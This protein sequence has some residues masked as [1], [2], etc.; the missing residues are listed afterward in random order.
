MQTNQV[1]LSYNYLV[2]NAIKL[3]FNSLLPTHYIL[4]DSFSILACAHD[5]RILHNQSYLP[6]SKL[7]D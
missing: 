4:Y 6:V 5:W 1:F 7:C 2:F 3:L